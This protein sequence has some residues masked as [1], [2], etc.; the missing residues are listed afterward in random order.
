[1]PRRT[2]HDCCRQHSRF[3]LTSVSARHSMSP[4]QRLPHLEVGEVKDESAEGQVA[5]PVFGTTAGG[6]SV[7]RDVKT[8]MLER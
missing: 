7:T 2:R 6:M 5:T 3:P 8:T 1:M 4:A